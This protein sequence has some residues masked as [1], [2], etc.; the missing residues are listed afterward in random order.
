MHSFA[1]TRFDGAAKPHGVRVAEPW[2]SFCQRFVSPAICAE[3]LNLPGYSLATFANDHRAKANVATVTALALDYDA[4]TTSIDAALALWARYEGFLHTTWSH[5]IERPRFRV[6]LRISRRITAEEHELILPWVFAQARKAGHAIDAKAKDPSRFWFAAGV[7]HTD[8]P[9]SFRALTGTTLEVE[10]VLAAVRAE[11]NEQKK[12][13]QP[14]P[15]PAPRTTP[16]GRKDKYTEAALRK[17]ID[18]IAGAPE[19][20]R[21]NVL[22]KEAFSLAGLVASG[23]LDEGRVR[24]ALLDAADVAGLKPAEARKTIE[25]GLRQ[26]SKKPRQVPESK[27]REPEWSLAET[28]A[29]GPESIDEVLEEAEALTNDGDGKPPARNAESF[30]QVFLSEGFVADHV[31]DLRFVHESGWICWNGTRWER[32][33]LRPHHLAKAAVKKAAERA[34]VVYEQTIATKVVGALLKANTVGAVVQLAKSD[35]RFVIHQRDLDADPWI[36]NC[37]N[38]VLDLKTGAL[39]EHRR[40]DLCLKVCPVAFDADAT[41]PQWERFLERVLPDPEVRAFVQRLAGYA[42]TGVIREHVL[43]I[44]FGK[45]RNGKGTFIE[46]LQFV[47]GDYARTVPASLLRVQ[48]NGDAHPTV[49]A[50]LFGVRFA[51]AQETEKRFVLAEALVKQLTGGDRIS[52]RYMRQDFFDFEPTHKLF[53]A[54]NYKP[55]IVGT[56]E[57]IWSRVMLIPWTAYI[58]PEERDTELK[59][60]L[61][62]EASG[63]LAWVVRGCVAWQKTGLAPPESVRVA[64]QGFRQESDAIGRFLDDRC[65]RLKGAR[66]QASALYQ[67]FE[68]WC[69][70]EGEKAESQKAFGSVLTEREIERKTIN[71]RQWYFDLGLRAEEQS[72]QSS[73]SSTSS[74]EPPRPVDDVAHVDDP[75][76]CRTFARARGTPNKE[77]STSSTSPTKPK[78]DEDVPSYPIRRFLRERCEKTGTETLLLLFEH[79]EAF[80]ENEGFGPGSLE[81]FAEALR[82]LGLTTS[83]VLAIGV[84][85]RP[86]TNLE[87]PG[88]PGGVS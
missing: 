67:A 41:A 47:L 84:S 56:D 26:G 43:P 27:P 28:P 50:Q 35:P 32:D 65:V 62:A 42:C 51:P 49:Q 57:G 71:G 82:G 33:D 69:R 11:Q 60:K 77:S 53:V 61:R 76:Y 15:S 37:T 81:S 10:V 16:A 75:N 54:S 17:A 59:N 64:T 70:G 52:A 6:L 3:K 9:Y 4:G 19:G 88:N 18:A 79:W 22:N 44:F 23:E 85:L 83:G 55:T 5:S 7:A 86:G 30:S 87:A 58:P 45:G 38:G 31:S 12:R 25:S 20:A 34:R 78:E 1:F 74:T 36:L 73:P 14:K 66:V 80:V 2:E 63:I 21:N 13:R 39:R 40:E 29:P 48:H 68:Q 46:T 24:E 72:E 8:A